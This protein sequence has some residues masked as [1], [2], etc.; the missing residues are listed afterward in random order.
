MT[1]E[2]VEKPAEMTQ[3]VVIDLGKHKSKRIKELKDGEGKLWDDMLAVV[4]EVKEMLGEDA[5]GKL[6]IPVVLIYQ[7]RPKTR[8]LDRL[9]FPGFK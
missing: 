5:N 8:R 6:I 9:I 3:P 7:Q 1:D 2:S 4:E